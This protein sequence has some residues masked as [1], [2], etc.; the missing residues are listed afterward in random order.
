MN[1]T[2]KPSIKAYNELQQAYDFF[3]VQLFN[4][5][6]PDLIITLQRGKR[7]YGYF[8]PERFSGESNLSELAMNPDYFG[9][10]SLVD[11]L[12]TLVHEMCHVWQHYI[13]TKKS[14]GGYHDKI[15]GNKME[16]IGLIPSNTGHPNGKKTGQQMTHY[17]ARNGLF[18]NAVYTLM[19]NGFSIS[20][21]D[22]WANQ[23]SVNTST[24][25]KDIL[26]DWLNITDDK[27]KELISKLTQTINKKP[28][29]TVDNDLDT[30]DFVALVPSAK[31]TGTRTK[32]TCTECGL[33]AWA[34]NNA[35]IMCGDCKLI[36]IDC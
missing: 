30:V 14:R 8:A 34:K 19:K 23:S 28:I 4:R 7:T 33:N 6:L 21:Y 5:E 31:G 11:T 26:D 29:D 27:N 20:W 13:S 24:I 1:P 32:F 12:S 35:N 18:Q 17:I 15:W 25:N 16:S 36:M 9:Q 10:R 2:Q 22:R 3:N